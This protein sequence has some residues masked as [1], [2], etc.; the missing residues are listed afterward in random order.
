MCCKKR[1]RRRSAVARHK[2]SLHKTQWVGLRARSPWLS[3]VDAW[4]A[5][6]RAPR[7]VGAEE[8]EDDDAG[9]GLLFGGQHV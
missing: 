6:S 8:E 9:T 2:L 5:L 4:S 1:R 7:F 3:L